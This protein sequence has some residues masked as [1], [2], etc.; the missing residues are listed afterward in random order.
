MGHKEARYSSSRRTKISQKAFTFFYIYSSIKLIFSNYYCRLIPP[1][2]CKVPP[3]S[4][5]DC[6]LH[7]LVTSGSDKANAS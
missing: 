7:N 1:Q 3:V 4:Q 6:D 5:T 2:A